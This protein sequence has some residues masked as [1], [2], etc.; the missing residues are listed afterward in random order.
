MHFCEKSYFI[1][2]K[3]D[4][5]VILKQIFLYVRIAPFKV[6]DLQLCINLDNAEREAL[7]Q[8]IDGRIPL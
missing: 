1:Y 8:L 4:H 5:K 7:L 6:H 2:L 3:E